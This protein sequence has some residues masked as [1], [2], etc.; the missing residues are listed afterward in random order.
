MNKTIVIAEDESPIARL[1]EF[2][3]KNNGYDVVV[4][5]NGEDVL[6]AIKHHQPLLVLLDVMMPVM[7]GFQVL[8][9]MKEDDTLKDIPVIMLTSKGQEKDVVRG[10]EMGV[11][12]YITKPFKPAEVLLQI[13]K[14]LK[15]I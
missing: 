6:D 2:K 4:T 8:K 14:V 11:E 9:R 12:E 1:I 15:K 3:L 10:L 5:D 7:D 13:K